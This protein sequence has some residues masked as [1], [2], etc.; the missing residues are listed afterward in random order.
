MMGARGLIFRFGK[1]F[2][3]TKTA[4][5]KHSWS[6]GSYGFA[7]AKALTFVCLFPA[8]DQPSPLDKEGI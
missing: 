5:F 2:Q 3:V 8:V 7:V 6:L 1:C 4:C